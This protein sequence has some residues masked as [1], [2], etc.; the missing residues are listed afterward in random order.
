MRRLVTRAPAKR[1]VKQSHVE[2]AVD[3]HWILARQIIANVP[4]GKALPMHGNAV[5]VWQ[6]ADGSARVNIWA[7]TFR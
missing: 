2:Q 1:G 3:G 6:Q 4:L 5:A 7:N